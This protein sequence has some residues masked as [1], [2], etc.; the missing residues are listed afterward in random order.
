[1]KFFRSILFVLA[2]VAGFSACQKELSFDNGGN[3][4]GS[5]KSAATGSCLPQTLNGIYKK[6]SVLTIDNFIDVQVDVSFAG[7]FVINSDT[8]NGYSFSKF[9][10]VGTGLNTIRLYAVGKPL[11][12]GTNTFTIRYDSSFCTFNVTVLVGSG[13]TTAVY[14]LVGSPGNCTGAT[15]TGTYKQGTA[16]TAGNTAIIGVL[17]TSPGTYSIATTAVNG[18]TFTAGGSFSA[19][20]PQIVTLTASGTPAASGAF[21]YSPNTGSN[22]CIFSVTY[23]ASGPVAVYTLGGSPTNCTGVV[24]NGTYQIGIPTSAA[25]TAKVDVTVATAGSYSMSTTTVNGVKFS[26]SGTFSVT[27]AQTVTLTASI[28]TPAASGTFNYPITGASTTC[29]FPVTYAPPPPPA[30]YTLSGNPGTCANIMVNGTYGAGIALN[31]SNNVVV[32][33]NVTTIGAYTLSTDLQNGMKFTVAGNFTVTGIQTVT[34][35]PVAGSNPVTGNTTTL[36]VTAPTTTCTFDIIVAAPN[37]RIYTF[38]IGTTVYTGPCSGSLAGSVP[39]QMSI[40]GGTGTNL[41]SLTL[42]NQ[43]GA[44]VTG[45][46]SGTSLAGLYA[47]FQYSEGFPTPTLILIG[48]PNLPSPLNTN[49]S[50]T[51]TSLDMVNLVVQGTFSGS[52]RDGS[53]NLISITNGTFKAD[54]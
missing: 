23:A 51:I 25:N 27:G 30:A 31:A 15:L 32:E 37:D 18:V 39:D 35:L 33:V 14:N 19:V 49:L 3:S 53:G 21:N 46:Y 8:V 13:G 41:F 44:I 45:N 11:A 22:S 24:L 1:M 42:N 16:M 5:L 7:A 12:A 54:F 6:D 48:D 52:V 40:T 26:A 17:V 9:G 28:A 38:K 43:T 2:I 34:L 47:S 20:G 50:A 4:V 10:N 29:T 36:T